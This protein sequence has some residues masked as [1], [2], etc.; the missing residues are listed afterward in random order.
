M[1]AIDILLALLVV[2]A[3]VGCLVAVL[4][5]TSGIGRL[6]LALVLILVVLVCCGV[7]L[8]T[9]HQVTDYINPTPTE[10]NR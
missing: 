6:G 1:T 10:V 4:R 9:G 8:P 5:M 7:E 3:G 2:V